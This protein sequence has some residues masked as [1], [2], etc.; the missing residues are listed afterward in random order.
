MTLV[1]FDENQTLCPHQCVCHGNVL[2]LFIFPRSIRRITKD[3]VIAI[4]E[5]VL[6]IWIQ[7]VV[8]KRP[9]AL[10]Q[11]LALCHTRRRTSA[12][13]EKISATTS[14]LTFWRLTPQIVI[15]LIICVWD[16]VE[17]ETEKKIPMQHAKDELKTKMTAAF[18]SL[19][20]ETLFKA[21]KRLRSR[22]EALVNDNGD[23]FEQI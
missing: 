13:R 10:Q 2:L 9:Y 18:I 19:N 17:R 5:L 7:R 21:F 11:E 16:A 15:S 3:Y 23:F 1:H 20:K 4:L 6:P 22:L 12:S 14:P 8:E